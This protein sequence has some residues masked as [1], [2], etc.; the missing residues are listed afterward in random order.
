MQTQAIETASTQAYFTNSIK[1]ESQTLSKPA[2]SVF[3][4]TAQQMINTEAHYQQNASEEEVKTAKQPRQN[5]LQQRKDARR[6]S[7]RA[8]QGAQNSDSDNVDMKE[9]QAQKDQHIISAFETP[10]GTLDYAKI[11]RLGSSMKTFEEF[12]KM[13]NPY[14]FNF[15]PLT[16]SKIARVT[17]IRSEEK[18]FVSQYW[19]DIFA[20]LMNEEQKASQSNIFKS[21]PT[22]T[23]FLRA[24]FIS[25]MF[26]TMKCLRYS[27]ETVNF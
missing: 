1:I 25:W 11:Q 18:R 27:D 20:S 6:G 17:M 16:K 14:F 26:H 24:K 15:A 4:V 7:Q 12:I 23:P 10:E 5:L 13:K 22:I 8:S 19:F 9:S 21:H 3:A 2:K